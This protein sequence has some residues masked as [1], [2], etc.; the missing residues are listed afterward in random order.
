MKKKKKIENKIRWAILSINI[1]SSILIGLTGIVGAA[2]VSNLTSQMYNQNMAPL[3]NVY[4]IEQDL[5]T[6]RMNFRN[7]VINRENAAPYITENEQI[8]QDIV[9]RIHS[10]GKHLSSTAEIANYQKI[11]TDFAAYKKQGFDVAMNYIRNGQFDAETRE[12]YGNGNTVSANLDADINREYT[13]NNE[14]AQQRNQTAIA[15]LAVVIVC[16]LVGTTVLIFIVLKTGKRVAFSISGP[17]NKMIAAAISISKGNLDVDVEIET[18]DETEDLA[19]A[20]A[21]MVEAL[22]RLEADV[23]M[24]I[25]ETLDGRLSTRADTAVHA[26]SYREIIGGVNQ[27]LDA[28]QKPLDAA[29]DFIDKLADGKHQNDMENTYN[30]YFA[31]LTDNLNRVRHSI[32]ILEEEADKLAKAGLTGNL[33][34][35][36]DEARLKGVYAKIIQG[37]NQTFDAVKKPLDVA[38]QFIRNLAEGKHQPAI[39]NNYNGYYASLTDNLNNVRKSIQ[40][41]VDESSKL[42]QAGLQGDLSV[43]GDTGVLKGNYAAII[44]GFNQTLESIVAPLDEAGAVLG[45]IAENDYTV[46]MSDRYAGMLCDFSVSVNN[47]RK[48]LLEI[49]HDLEEVGGGRFDSLADLEKIG[50][51]SENDKML[52]SLIAMM[53]AVQGLIVHTDQLAVS[54][55]EGDLSVRVDADKFKGEYSRI[56]RDMNRI[57]GAVE[58]PIVESSKVLQAFSQG[59]LTVAVTG[60]YK[61]EYNLIKTSLNQA[62]TSFHKLLGEISVAADQVAVGANQVSD[63]SQALSQGA[64]EQASSVEELTSSIAELAVQTRQNAT[65]ASQANTLASTV[66]TEALN[67]NEKMGQMLDAMSRINESSTDISKII[68]VIE[69]IAFQ[70]NIL[71]LNAAVEAARAGEYGKGFAVVAEEV[72]S[73]A[74]KSAEAAKNTTALIEGSIGKVEA[75]AK[76]ANET[77]DMLHAISESIQKATA[78]VGNIAAASNDQAAAIAQIDQGIL[79]VSTVVQTNSATAEESAASSEELSGQA[80]MLKQMVGNF[81]LQSI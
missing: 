78:L 49:Q 32:F 24:L 58:A 52:P 8:Y 67:G 31:S 47:V 17:I 11:T 1:C 57:M 19:Q 13:I 73:L 77:A 22:R 40:Y 71:A 35:R 45:R 66:Q 7:M 25:S 61:G 37:V 15:V 68:K 9:N 64:T 27:M 6:L 20:F 76:I 21:G 16:I 30:G 39:E 23:Q 4:K 46:E 14:E 63:A 50:K 26:G 80:D 33:D 48:R 12:L 44:H 34:V 10:A 60:E 42:T 2:V 65:D 79:Q 36:G 43:R 53:Q 74:A 69:D 28:V 62:I 54:V 75:G 3:T 55:I 51:R 81:Q 5:L 41:L 70:T 59:N 72:R 29:S 56:I 18:G 38:A